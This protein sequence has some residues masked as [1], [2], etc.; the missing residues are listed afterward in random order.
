MR[1]ML[2]SRSASPGKSR[3]STMNGFDECKMDGDELDWTS[4][5]GLAAADL[6]SPNPFDMYVSPTQ[7]DILTRFDPYASSAATISGP[8]LGGCWCCCCTTTVPC[9]SGGPKK[10]AREAF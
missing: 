9:V 4:G 6:T 3:P 2:N 10:M 1:R 8:A 7:P 5:N